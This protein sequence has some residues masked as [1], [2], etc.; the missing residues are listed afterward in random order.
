[1]FYSVVLVVKDGGGV[2]LGSVLGPLSVCLR[3]IKPSG[4]VWS[5]DG[6]EFSEPGCGLSLSACRR[7]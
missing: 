1:M 2:Q 4:W 3:E 5:E 7:L 6:L